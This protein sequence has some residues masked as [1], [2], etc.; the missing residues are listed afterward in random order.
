MIHFA[1]A[2]R[3]ILFLW[4]TTTACEVVLLVTRI[5]RRL[6]RR[7][8]YDVILRLRPDWP[9]MRCANHKNDSVE[10]LRKVKQ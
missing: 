6:L 10:L 2:R 4:S 5:V 9:G 3:I 7:R 8:R 1:I